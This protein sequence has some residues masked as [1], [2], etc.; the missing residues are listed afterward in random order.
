MGVCSS[1]VA[2]PLTREEVKARRKD[3]VRFRSKYADYA[4]KITPPSNVDFTVEIEPWIAA[5]EGTRGVD[6]ALATFQ[7]GSHTSTREINFALSGMMS[8]DNN[9]DYQK[10]VV[11]S[12][13]DKRT[14]D[15]ISAAL[16]CEVRNE[17]QYFGKWLESVGLTCTH[18]YPRS[19]RQGVERS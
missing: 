4:E 12:L 10:S 1:A 6:D 8:V 14:K 2:P 9:Y 15:V 13:K 19:I 5:P 11:L 3:L 7:R 17:W 18:K 16:M